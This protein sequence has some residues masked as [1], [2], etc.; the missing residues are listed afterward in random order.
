MSTGDPDPRATPVGESERVASIDVLRGVAVLGIL[1]MNVRDF[2]MP[3]AAFDNPAFPD[4]FRWSNFAAWVA[5]NLF[6]EDKMIAIFSMLFGAGILIFA[7]RAA[8]RGAPV[9]ALSYR[10]QLWLLVFGLV[11]A[12]GFWFG[13]ILTTYAVCGMLVFPLRRLSPRVLIVIGFLVFS[14]AI[15]FRQWPDVFDQFASAVFGKLH[16]RTKPPIPTAAAYHGT[17]WDLFRWRAWLNWYWHVEGALGY[18]FWRCSGFMLAGMALMKLG[19]FDA[20]RSARWYRNLMIAGYGHRP[21]AGG[22]RDPRGD[23][24]APA[25]VRPVRGL[26]VGPVAADGDAPRGRERSPSATSGS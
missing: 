10:R 7:D 24:A 4:G 16:E 19:V 22:L 21:A 20:S 11:H 3:L 12:Y 2:G 23:R 14:V 9:A 18:D 8:A 5:G 17:W 6:F 15:L 1:V 13:D 25:D 26:V